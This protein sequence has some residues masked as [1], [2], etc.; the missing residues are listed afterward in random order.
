MELN[1]C[2]DK[3]LIPRTYIRLYTTDDSHN[4]SQMVVVEFDQFYLK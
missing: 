2:I 4:T 3:E 1:G